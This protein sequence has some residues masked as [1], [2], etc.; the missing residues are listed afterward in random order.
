MAETLAESWNESGQSPD[1]SVDGALE[2]H[3]WHIELSK[4]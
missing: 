3:N 4:H 1:Y 2:V